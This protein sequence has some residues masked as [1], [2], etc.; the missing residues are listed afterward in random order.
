MLY[1]VLGWTFGEWLSLIGR[2]CVC[3]CAGFGSGRVCGY[4]QLIVNS[5]Y[6][7]IYC[8]RAL[9]DCDLT[10]ACAVQLVIERLM[11]GSF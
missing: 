1:T 11:L 6:I 10:G 3:V 4:L 8:L 2:V 7:Y 9:T 5:R